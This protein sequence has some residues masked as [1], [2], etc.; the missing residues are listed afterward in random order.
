MRCVYK[1]MS[2]ISIVRILS[3]ACEIKF[4]IVSNM[5]ALRSKILSFLER[6]S[7]LNTEFLKRS[8][9]SLYNHTA[10]DFY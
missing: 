6:E 2:G 3:E 1:I 8:A 5:S 4:E 7:V 9:K 10:L